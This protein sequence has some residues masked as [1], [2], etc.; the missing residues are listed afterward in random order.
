MANAR[1]K[2]G[3]TLAELLIAV[4]IFAMFLTGIVT[5]M[6]DMYRSSRRI[7][8]EEQIY[9]DMRAMMNQITL[10]IEEN[11]ID[12]E[13]Y[14]R[15]AVGGE[16]LASAIDPNKYSYGDYAKLFYDMGSD[17]PGPNGEGAY[18]NYLPL[19]P[20]E[21][22]PGCVVDKTTLDTNMGMNPALGGSPEDATAFCG[23]GTVVGICPADT[24]A[25][26]VQDHL[27]LINETGDKKTILALEPVTK[28]I[29][30]NT[31]D[32]KTLSIVW[33]NGSD[34][35]GNDIVDTWQSGPEFVGSI[36]TLLADLDALDSDP[37][38]DIYDN[39]IPMSPLR[40]N[41]VDVK[42]IVYPL[43]DPYKAFAETDPALDTL[44]QPHVTV[45]LTVQP[46]ATE[47][48]DYLG[49]IPQKTLQTTVYSNVKTNVKS[50]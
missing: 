26:H 16:Y 17:G 35:T 24:S 31:Y 13:E 43:E 48:T 37:P 7:A 10:F 30:S 36:G 25:F 21:D 22:D 19:T 12:Y 5:L 33:L 34:T 4:A 42:F 1:T 23:P 8:L 27:Y 11:A 45:L 38:A 50:Y 39:F 28:T 41:I 47:L 44:A 9:Q 15:A 49:P 29:D 46:S 32:E 2:K 40:T 20:V 3:F 14:Y 6:V 18:C